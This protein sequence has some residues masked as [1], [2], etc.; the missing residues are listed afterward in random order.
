M[1]T[2]MLKPG[3]TLRTMSGTPCFVKELLGAGGQG[4]VYRVTLAGDW[5]MA[6]KWYF[7]HTATKEQWQGLE[8]LLSKGTPNDKFLWPLDLVRA[9]VGTQFGYLM[10]LRTPQ[11]K[12]IVDLMK[13][14]IEPDPTFQA[15]T[16][17]G[18]QLADSYFQLHVR[19][20]CYRDISFG[21][22]FFDLRSGE[23][24]ICD[25]DNVTVNGL[26]GG[27]VLGTSR[28]MAPEI[29]RGEALPSTETD[30]FSLAV[31]LFYLFMFH[32]PLEGMREADIHVFDQA[33][34]T[35]IYGTDPLFIFDPNNNAN[36]PVRGYQD[37]P[38]IF[39][40]IY[41]QFLRDLFIRAFT[42]GLRDPQNGRVLEN[43]WRAA[44]VRLHDSVFY[45]PRCSSQNFYDVDALKKSGGTPPP[46]WKCQQR[47]ILPYRI[48]IDSNIIMLN[49][50][51]KLYPHHIDRQ[52]KWD[53]SWPVA[54]VNRHPN[55]PNRW[56]L[57]TVSGECWVITKLD[58]TKQDVAVG[59]NAP[60]AV[61]VRI[62]F[63]ST[64]GEIRY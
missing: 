61:N 17:T 16:I 14:R 58:G 43:E 38:Q 6:L 22:V 13:R 64:E 2:S 33:A 19:G 54:R 57:K 27:G 34:M 44:M 48:R 25:N 55:D 62:N 20:L 60:L 47:V 39:W 45:C 7:P 8:T 63:G 26:A 40:P 59:Q 5:S 30:R 28:F 42:A 18:R 3:Q 37:N 32:H 15:L 51:T 9:D 10:S 36:A 4:E 46:C 21:N 50:D 11:F 29:V 23:V 35:K 1:S 56:G 12:S 53:F 49:E 41:P 24:L 31:L 52:K